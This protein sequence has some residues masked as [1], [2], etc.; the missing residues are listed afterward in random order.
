[1]WPAYSRLTEARKQ[2]VDILYY[3]IGFIGIACDPHLRAAIERNNIERVCAI[4]KD[5]QIAELYR[6]DTYQP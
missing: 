3:K 6:R 2:A 4:V 1:M 5:D